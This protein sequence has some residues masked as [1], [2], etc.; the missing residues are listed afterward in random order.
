MAK[1]TPHTK[2]TS[3]ET[4]DR[5]ITAAGKVLREDGYAAASARAIAKEAGV[6]SALVFYHFGG[7]DQVLL[8]A[9]DRS[10][11]KRMALHG[12]AAARATS[13]EELVEVAVEIYR[14]DLEGGYLAEFCELVAAAVANPDLRAEINARAEPW[15]ALIEENWERVL[16]GSPLARLL[17]AREVA[18]GAITYYLGANLFSVLDA[19]HSRTEGVFELAARLA[20]RARLLTLRL[21]RRSSGTGGV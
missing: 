6:N 17:P 11:E 9:L 4:R 15:I 16:G 3:E 13:L 18:Y 5:L 8:A 19:D 14:T 2:R 20:P 7:V 10:S 1:S 21:P 12:A